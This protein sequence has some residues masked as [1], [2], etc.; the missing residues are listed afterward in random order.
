MK[1]FFMASFL[2]LFLCSLTLLPHSSCFAAE[3]EAVT[4]N[5][6]L[7]Y[8]TVSPTID[9]FIFDEDGTFRR[10]VLENETEGEGTYQDQGLVFLVN[11]A[12]DDGDTTYNFTGISL[13]SLIII[14][15]GNKKVIED[16]E[17]DTDSLYF[18]GIRGEAI[19]D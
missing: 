7:T 4:G 15:T 14:G 16:D 17:T 18:I 10:P 1:K 8:C 11:W 6:Y 12:S 3:I 13:V 19:P 5:S 9:T 2:L